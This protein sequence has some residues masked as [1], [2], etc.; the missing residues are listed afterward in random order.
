M[1]DPRSLPSTVTTLTPAQRTAILN[2]VRRAA[3]AEILPRFRALAPHQIDTK[4]GP[5]DLVTEAD[6][7]AEAMIARGLARMFPNALIVGEEAVA[8][9]PDLPDRIADAETA[10]TID[11]VDGTWNYASGLATFGVILSMTRYGQPVFGMLYD[12]MGDDV[13]WAAQGEDAVMTAPGRAPRR[14]RVS[15]G[16]GIGELVGCIPLYML[17]AAQQG[18]V[19]AAFPRFRRVLNL[20]CSCHEFRT[21]AQGHVDFVLSAGLTPWD[22]AAGAL[23]AARAGGH[24]AMLD[25]S[26]YTADRR[27]GYLLAAANAETWN[28]VRDALPGLSGDA[29]APMVPID[30]GPDHDGPDAGAPAHDGPG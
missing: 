12:P 25:G 20:R 11:P 19:A 18:A 9:N 5:Q 24:V 22:H 7:A 28:A 26:A 1:A 3:R 15:P 16:G 10:F 8:A 2:L 17:P 21:L 23:I 14:L 27:T 30:D 29:P 4:A 6:I 13:I